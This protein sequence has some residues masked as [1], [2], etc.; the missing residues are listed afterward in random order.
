MISI[1]KYKNKYISVL[2][3]SISTF[4]GVSEPN[5]AAFYDTGRK[6]LSNVLTASDTWWGAVVEQL[7]ARLLINNSISGSTVTWHPAYEIQAYGCSDERTSS[8]SR[9]GVLPDVIF[10]YLGTNDWSMGVPLLKDNKTE[11]NELAVF[12][13]AY[14]TMLEKL[15]ANY[16]KAEI[17]CL[18]LA[19]SRF[20]K[21]EAFEFPFCRGGVHISEYCDIIKACAS[22]TDCKVID[23]YN[24]AEPYDTVD[25][26]HANGVGMNTIA[27]AVLKSL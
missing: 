27:N 12:S 26:V 18:T 20:S 13:C 14:Q 2:G 4:E 8:L 16:P 10:V 9:D 19:V 1:D 15:H 25:G 22:K 11:K 7:G 6:L 3:D 21:S 17:H 24:N 5:G 23:L